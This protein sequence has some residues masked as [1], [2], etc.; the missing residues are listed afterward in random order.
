MDELFTSESKAQVYECLHGLMY[1]NMTTTESIGIHLS[2]AKLHACFTAEVLCYD[3]G[4]HLHKYGR[5]LV[6]P[7][8]SKAVKY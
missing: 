2:I 8:L 5:N 7:K 4:C 1:T 6:C 3:D